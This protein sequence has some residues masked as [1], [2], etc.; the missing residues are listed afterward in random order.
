MQWLR[1]IIGGLH[2]LVRRQRVE[3]ELDEELRA[4]V[5]TSI[6]ENMRAGMGREEAVRAARVEMGSLETVKDHVRDVG[7]ETRL[8]SLWCDARYAVRTLHKSPGFASVVVLTLALGVG[9]TTAIFSLLDAVILKSLPVRSPEQLVMVTGPGHYPVYQAFRQHTDTFIDLFASS[10]VSE[11]D[12]EIQGG[13]RERANVSLVSGSYFSTLGVSA[14]IGRTFTVDD[15]RVPGEHPVAVISYGYWQR[16]FGRDPPLSGQVVR[17]S[18]TPVAIIGVTPP[19][20]FG[21]EVGAAPDMW[22]P[23]TMWGN[24]VPGRNLLQSPGTSWLR[25]VGRVK[26]EVNI[27]QAETRL[28]LTFRRVLLDVFGP[29]AGEDVRRDIAASVV[30]LAPAN[31]GVSN[32]RARFARPLQLL[33]GAVALVLLIACANIASLMLARATARR[34]EIDLRIALGMSRARLIRQLLTESLVLAA[35]GGAVAVAVAWLGREA[36][37]RLIS[38]DGARLPV[39]VTTDARLLVFVAVTSLATALLFGLAPVWQSARLSVGTSLVVRREAVAHPRQRLSSFLVVA[40]VVLSLVL[41]MGAGLFVRTIANLRKVD[42]GFAPEHLLIIDVNPQAAGYRGDRAIALNRRLLERMTAA[43]GVSSVSLSEN[44]VLM[45]RNSSTDLIRPAG[46]V[47]GPEGLPR[48]QFDW[49][50]PR[51]FSTMGTPLLSGRDFSERDD[52]GSPH[53]VAINDEMARLFFGTANPIGR[54]LVWGEDDAQ[55]PLEIVAVTRDVKHSGPRDV[56]QLRFWVPYFQ[57]SLVRENWIPA[58]TRF[59]VRTVANPAAVAP[60]LRQLIPSEDPR[61]SVSSLD[62]GPQLVSRT[63]VQERLVTTLLIA[64]CVLAVGLACLGLYG[65]I[66][67]QVVQRTNEMGIR[68][69]LGAQR[70]DVLW[71]M[72][73]R[74]LLWIGAGIAIGVPLALSASRLVQSLLFGLRANDLGSLIGAAAVMSVMGLLAGYIPAR[75]ASRVDPV[76]ALRA[77]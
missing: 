39:A 67:Y 73:R 26:P 38:A 51:Y 68:M 11:L 33:M 24:V 10:G 34:R 43:P 69:A 18:G 25:I 77:E 74:A 27:P 36:L 76:I 37:L 9:A 40:Q 61:L 2:A 8:E 15:D 47:A 57:M 50:G 58:S 54:R 42:L 23:L 41:L 45:G 30:R 3:R 66:A 72:L 65:L 21:E 29:K 53:V 63:L 7:W 31:K 48:T 35:L 62:I 56:P 75:R 28:T 5:E 19:G 32:L 46:L 22:L 6:A 70:R 44:G 55:K 20:F 52:I 12:A 17:I 64:F 49:V 60:I 13:Q 1:R 71:V 16:R 4:Y 14:V 59:L